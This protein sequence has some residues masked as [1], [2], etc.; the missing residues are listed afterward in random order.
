M[1]RLILIVFLLLSADSAIG[2]GTVCYGDLDGICRSPGLR[3]QAATE[4]ALPGDLWV[5]GDESRMTLVVSLRDAE[6]A[7]PPVVVGGAVIV[8][9]SDSTIA[10]A[11]DGPFALTDL[12]IRGSFRAGDNLV[13]D[14]RLTNPNTATVLFDSPIVLASIAGVTEIELFSLNPAGNDMQ[15]TFVRVVNA[16]AVPAL[17][18]LRPTDDTGRPGGEVSIVIAPGAAVQVNSADLETG[19]PDK[20]LAGAFG[21][22]TGKWR[23]ALIADAKV[24]AQTFVRNT[25]TGTLGALSPVLD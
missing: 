4:V 15:Q 18:R 16:D 1:Y 5:D 17:V 2:A 23:V 9:L 25:Q 13:A 3:V 12:R 11:H 24:R 8:G 20:G 10:L 19:N 6:F 7:S 22:G 14:V 21:R